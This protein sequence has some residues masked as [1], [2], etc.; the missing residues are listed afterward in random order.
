MTMTTS[1]TSTTASTGRESRKRS[2]TDMEDDMNGDECRGLAHAP[3]P[4]QVDPWHH[5]GAVAALERAARGMVE[6]HTWQ[7][8]IA[9]DG[10][11]FTLTRE[12]D[13]RQVTRDHAEPAQ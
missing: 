3:V 12:R 1:V 7:L 10:E 5:V 8:R 9:I 11:R 13:D 6:A 2:I 4:A